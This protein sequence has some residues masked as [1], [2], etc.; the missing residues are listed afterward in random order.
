MK[1]GDIV[2]D[3]FEIEA[4]AGSGGMGA[5]YR[6]IDRQ[7]KDCHARVAI[8]LLRGIEVADDRRFEREAELLATFDH[9]GIVR[10]LGHG[11][12]REG[13]RWLVM[14]WLEGEDLDDRLTRVGMSVVQ[15]LLVVRRA[16]EALAV[17]HQNG[18]VHRDLKPSNLFLVD[19]DVSNVKVL[20]FGVALDAGRAGLTKTG[21]ICGT[22]GFMAPEQARGARDRVDARADVFALGCLLF[23]CI[24]GE[25]AIRGA[26]AIATL[27]KTVVEEP[28]RLRDRWEDAPEDLDALIHAMMAKSPEARPRDASEVVARL[29]AL[30]K[31]AADTVVVPRPP[32]DELHT[33]ARPR[34]VEV[35]TNLHPVPTAFFGR[36][37]ELARLDELVSQGERLIT[38]IGPG[39][40]GK[41]RL[42]QR[43]AELHALDFSKPD[44][45][46][47]PGGGAWFCDLTETRDAAGIVLAVARALDL[48]LSSEKS[49]DLVQLLGERL[50]ERGRTLLV[51]DNCE[52]VV[53]SAATTIARLRDLAPSTVFLATSRERLRIAGERATEVLPLSLPEEGGEVSASPA[54]QLF[55][56]RAR[57]VKS[58][59]SLTPTDAQAV[60]D[61]VRRLDGLPLAIELAAARID[62]LPPKAMLARLSQRFE[63]LGEGARETTERQRTL[64]GAIDWSWDLLAPHEQSALA[65]CAVFR[66]GFVLAAAEEVV[67]LAR[68]EGVPRKLDVIQGLRDKSLVRVQ[69]MDP[70]GEV[71]FGL[72]ESIRE[73]AAEKLRASGDEDATF[74]RHRTHHLRLD[75]D[76]SAEGYEDEELRRL[77]AELENLG[78]IHDRLLAREKHDAD[79][80]NALLRCMLALSRIYI[81]R[82]P[83]AVYLACLDRTLKKEIVALASPSYAATVLLRRGRAK[84]FLGS[85]AE[86]LADLEASLAMARKAGYNALE[87]KVLRTMGTVERMAGRP[88]AARA[89][90]ESAIRVARQG[91]YA[92]P[93]AIALSGLAQLEYGMGRA[94]EAHQHLRECIAVG[95]ENGVAGSTGLLSYILAVVLQELGEMKEARLRYREAI[96][97]AR[98]RNDRGY[99]AWFIGGFGQLDHEEGHL[100][101]ARRGYEEALAMMR[102][103]GDRLAETVLL[104][105]YGGVLAQMG[106]TELAER[107]LDDAEAT[108]RRIGIA[109]Q[110]APVTV[111]RGQLDLARAKACEASGDREGA[112]RNLQ[113]AE[114][115]LLVLV[116]PDAPSDDVRFA[117]R[118]LERA[119]RNQ[120]GTR[121]EGTDA[122]VVAVDGAWFKPP[123]GKR[124][125]LEKRRALRRVLLTLV[126]HRVDTPGEPISIEAIVR[127][128]WPGERM[129]EDA[130]LNRA[131]VALTRLRQ[132]GIQR[133]LQS[134]EA[135]HL[136]DPTV[137]IVLARE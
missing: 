5:V 126:Q 20:D 99:L 9:P 38:L 97:R 8:K 117:K 57:M 61:L 123:R 53:E 48:P 59:Y 137:P 2:A 115:R 88:R 22:P 86:S 131:K 25:D 47:K 36:T 64:R 15:G 55:V 35:R 121:D 79:S 135:G 68:F 98:A 76:W 34:V 44:A 18:V 96:D 6:A 80:A 50:S 46:A 71:R 39:G 107:V 52:Q 3:R 90:L 130:A 101:D 28:P 73:Y 51:L 85:W 21:A 12:T 45:R 16:A 110:L 13:V 11:T 89:H 127:G 93:L 75:G 81:A 119:M 43:Y 24:V 124:I 95:G 118:I 136:L 4:L 104:A 1:P 122:L 82:G 128:G 49:S 31:I 132:L 63:V 69:S 32:T 108:V 19:R 29:D 92:Q 62:V 105:H 114:S 94:K 72:Y 7:A 58:D 100:D 113:A 60:A 84:L 106:E 77:C 40:T 129:R 27:L 23:R 67:D 33:L 70:S 103:V 91:N 116:D 56:D 125:E 87:T 83:M 65:Q 66:G 112:F 120:R 78:A 134:V 74:D 26:D 41:T 37:T 102:E 109:Y 30:G 14:E 111:H 54:V 42:A 133:L 10:Y 17:A